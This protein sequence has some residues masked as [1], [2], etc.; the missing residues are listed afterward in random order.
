MLDSHESVMQ[1]RNRLLLL[2]SVMTGLL[3]F[4]AITFRALHEQGGTNAY[5]LIAESF[6]TLSP[7]ASTCFGSDCA[8][9]D[10][11][12]YVVFPPFPALL[13]MPL[14]WLNGIGTVGFGAISIALWAGALFLWNRI[15]RHLE[16][17]TPSRLWLFLAIGFASPLFYVSLRADGVW[18]F[19]QSVAFFFVTLAIQEALV[20]RNLLT[21]GLAIG[22]A[23]L[24]RQLSVF[25][26]PLLLLLWMRPGESVFRIDRDRISG[27]VRLAIPILAALICYFGYNYWR[28][29]NPLESGY[30]F[31]NFDSEMFGARVGQYGIWNKAYVVFNFFYF[32]FQGF[33]AEFSPP[34]RLSLQGLD[35]AGSSFLAASP[36]LLLGFFAKRNLRTF[37]AAA[38][39][40]GFTGTLLFYHSNGFSQY[41]VQRYGL[42]WLP[43]ALVVM[44]PALTA[45]RLEWFRLLVAWG[46]VL[47]V[48]TVGVLALT[49]GA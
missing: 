23:L 20:R 4:A 27:A 41:N 46:I 10:G 15:F 49:K 35:P 30:R 3:L 12:T 25:Y 1:W 2:A 16:V 8:I 39:V 48:V 6:L 5:A 17:E 38:M 37:V 7:E 19:A 24:S 22:A 18:F 44:A 9:V 28:F 47:N 36:W 11:K 45:Q 29:G 42:D 33:H 40:I 21:A 13:A 32:F 14:V 34:Q 43:A 26:A 31:I